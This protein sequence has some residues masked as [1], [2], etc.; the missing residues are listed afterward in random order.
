M[1][2]MADTHAALSS[3]RCSMR[4]TLHQ[5]VGMSEADV[6]KTLDS[7]VRFSGAQ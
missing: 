1:E 3:S 6:L 7:P 5:V 4:V 2:H